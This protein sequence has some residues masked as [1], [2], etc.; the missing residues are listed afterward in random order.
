MKWLTISLSLVCMFEEH[1]SFK[2]QNL[3]WRA[4]DEVLMYICQRL[5]HFYIVVSYDYCF[6]VYCM[7]DGCWIY[8]NCEVW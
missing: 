3:F 8:P 6:G 5:L 4:C 1:I 7:V 2:R